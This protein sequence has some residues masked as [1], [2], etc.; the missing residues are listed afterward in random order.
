MNQI[1]QE[2]KPVI[3]CPQWQA[4]NRCLVA[5]VTVSPGVCRHC[6][7]KKLG[8]EHLKKTQ[9]LPV[10]GMGDIIAAAT[11]AIGIKPCGGCKER[12][13]KLNQLFPLNQPQGEVVP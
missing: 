5:G 1:S 6:L 7:E 3:D 13:A 9:A 4:P 8:G 11:T 2:I 12:Q 10:R